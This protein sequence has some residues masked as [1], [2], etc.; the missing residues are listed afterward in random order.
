[1][2]TIDDITIGA[3]K[4]E[5]NAVIEIMSC[6]NHHY[7]ITNEAKIMRTVIYDVYKKISRKILTNPKKK[8]NTYNLKLKY[9]EVYFLEKF[10]IVALNLEDNHFANTLMGKLNQKLA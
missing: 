6:F 10:I 8:T 2:K 7:P 3:S 5:L 9:H 1:M 4:N